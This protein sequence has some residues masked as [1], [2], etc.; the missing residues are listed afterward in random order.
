MTTAISN[1]SSNS[2]ILIIFIAS[3]VSVI[4]WFTYSITVS[5]KKKLI[6]NEFNLLS[7]HAKRNYK[8]ILDHYM[9]TKKPYLNN[10][11]S[12][13]D[14][15]HDM[16]LSTNHIEN[17]IEKSFR[18]SFDNYINKFRVDECIATIME[19]NQKEVNMNELGTKSGFSNFDIFHSN[20]TQRVGM[21]PEAFK[22][23]IIK[24]SLN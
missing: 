16:S 19:S 15:A 13:T 10:N 8:L 18:N 9:K 17:I 3:I 11:L 21:T 6:K 2:Y 24:I 7:Y 23:K 20:F 14:V 1:I 5:V 22:N 12:L 4:S